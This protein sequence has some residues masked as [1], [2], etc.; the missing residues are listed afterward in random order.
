MPTEKYARAKELLRHSHIIGERY[1]LYRRALF[2]TEVTDMR[3]DEA[4]AKWTTHTS[5][6]DKI[7][8]RF[9]IPAA[10]P[11]HRPKLPGLKGIEEFNGHAFHSSRW[12]FGYTG[13]DSDGGLEKLKDK[14]LGIIGEFV[15]ALLTGNLIAEKKKAP[16]PQQSKLCLIS[17]SGL[18]NST[19]SNGH[20][21][22]STSEE[23]DPLT[24]NG[25]LL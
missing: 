8:S 22:Q 13:G 14:R 2:Q 7:K 12:D 19:S 10:G 5:R 11:L 17:A 23:I 25:Q 24:E 3:W 1:D 6:G 9:I 21:H 15:H 20:P 4:E 18:R 16:E